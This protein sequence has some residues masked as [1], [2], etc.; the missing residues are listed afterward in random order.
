MLISLPSAP[1]RAAAANPVSPVPAA[2]SRMV[3]P[4]WGSSIATSALADGR[5]TLH[6]HWRSALPA[7]RH[8]LPGVEAFAA[9]FLEI[10]RADASSDTADLR[11]SR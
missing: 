3:C 2:S 8:L 1:I 4:G 5:E 7:G 10:H 9:V 6:T 11:E